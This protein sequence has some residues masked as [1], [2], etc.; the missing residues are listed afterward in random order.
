MS[1]LILHSGARQV[2]YEEL[3]SAKAPEPTETWFPIS[4]AEVVGKVRNALGD[5]GFS[6]HEE[7]HALTRDSSRMFSTLDLNTELAPGVKLSAGI[8]NSY[9][10]SLAIGFA[11]GTRVFICDNGA[12]NS[13]QT[14]S[15]KHTRYGGQRFHEALCEAVKRLGQ[16][17][18]VEANRIGQYRHLDI[19]D[20]E[21]DS[22]IL[23]A[24][25][26]EVISN[27]VLPEVIKQWYEPAYKEF[28]PR[29]MWSLLNAFT[30]ALGPREKSN[31]QEFA[32]ITIRL[33]GMLDKCVRGIELASA[34]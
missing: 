5:A 2:S 33:N 26:K 32:G 30:T 14:I 34:L 22:I 20:K 11:A 10:R 18:E 19:R 29:T 25:R 15:R 27:R 7:R 16:F 13:E 24:Y 12:F 31:P 1:N 6:I 21:A 9:D 8:R 17:K 4:H 3:A 28:E 23:Q